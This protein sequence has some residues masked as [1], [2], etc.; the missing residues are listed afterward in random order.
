MNKILFFFFVSFC[1]FSQVNEGFY[2]S[3][4]LNSNTLKSN[5]II[6]STGIGYKGG[7]IFCVGE[8]ENEN[9][10]IELFYSN[11]TFSAKTIDKETFTDV[12]DTKFN[13]GSLDFG[14]YYNYYFYPVNEDEFY[15]GAQ[16]GLTVGL[17]G[18]IEAG[19]S[20]AE[21]RVVLP[22]IIDIQSAF[23]EIPVATFSPGAGIT[24][25]YN[26]LRFTI[27]YNHGLTNILKLTET[28]SRDESNRYTGPSF[29]GNL[30]A[31]SLTLSY[32][33]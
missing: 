12:Q 26:D 32:N 29:K 28:D 30:S 18:A 8:N 4:G 15:I 9:F 25:G 5:D 31:I 24:G 27:R 3:A 2:F 1:G 33:L 20:N 22:N 14:M 23:S 16:G 7:I 11:S 13:Y 6:S 21:N 19:G 10:Q 17:A